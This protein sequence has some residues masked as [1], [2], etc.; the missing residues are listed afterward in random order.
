MHRKVCS[1]KNVCEPMSRAQLDVRVK[2]INARRSL[3]ILEVYVTRLFLS[4]LAIS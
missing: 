2:D 3:Y 4:L 1:V